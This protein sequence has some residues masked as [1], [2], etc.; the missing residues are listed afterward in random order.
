VT[1]CKDIAHS[2]HDACVEQQQD[3]ASTCTICMG[4]EKC[5]SPGTHTGK[6]CEGLP[7]PVVTQACNPQVMLWVR[8][9]VGMGIGQP[10]DTHRLPMQ[11]PKRN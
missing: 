8:V 7:I 3:I 10:G 1:K 5:G 6:L 11:H 9:G 2:G 4:V